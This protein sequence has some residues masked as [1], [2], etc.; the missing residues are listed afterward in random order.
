M[1]TKLKYTNE[2]WDQLIPG[3]LFAYREIP[4]NSTGYPPF[5]LELGRKPRVPSDILADAFSASVLTLVAPACVLT[6]VSSAFVPTLV[7]SISAPTLV[8]S[9]PVPTLV[10]SASVPTLVSS[11]SVPS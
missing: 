10:S 4:H 7:S 3:V 2:N 11:A 8:S 5:E 6:L 9:A 1:F